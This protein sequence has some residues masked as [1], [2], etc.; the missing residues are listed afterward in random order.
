MSRHAQA[1]LGAILIAGCVDPSSTTQP[2]EPAASRN[3]A[4]SVEF[5]D[6]GTLG[7]TSSAATAINPSGQVVGWADLPGNSRRHAFLWENGVMTDLATLGGARSEAFDI[8]PSGDIIG[9]SQLPGTT[10]YH[11]F[12]WRNG[13]M[14]DLGTLGGF[15]STPRAINAAGQIVGVSYRSYTSP[16]AF[17][18]RNGV[19]KDLGP[20]L[21]GY[22][23]D[24]NDAGDVVGVGT[25]P[26]GQRAVLWRNGQ[27]IDLGTLGGPNS[28]A[29]AI[30]N[31]GQV[32]G[33]SQ[34]TDVVYME[35][36]F[37]WDDG[38]MTDLGSLGGPS[39]QSH[40]S[41]INDRGDI[42]GISSIGPAEASPYHGVL[43]RKGRIIDLGEIV[44]TASNPRGQVA[45]YT[46]IW[47][48][49]EINAVAVIWD[50]GVTT[51]LGDLGGVGPSITRDIN[52]RGWIIGYARL[53]GPAWDAGTHAGMWAPKARGR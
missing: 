51:V 50:R 46:W 39:G 38:K 29:V 44:P 12:L 6:F 32:V 31:A 19:M 10:W 45:G 43:W 2:L 53:P 9:F 34:T 47:P 8:N 22:A 5:I 33:W 48:D 3:A 30:N 13:T 17:L 25:F 24:I 11:G 7:G 20:P 36:A 18:W 49:S 14:I 15:G 28:R 23:E 16:A 40:A 21:G 4:P 35:H 26:G 27:V 52:P 1:M 41:G 42:Y 37:L